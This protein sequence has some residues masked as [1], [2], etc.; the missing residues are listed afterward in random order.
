M[1]SLFRNLTRT[2]PRRKKTR[3]PVT[4][5]PTLEGLET[6]SLL[7]ANPLQNGLP[8]AS[9][10]FQQ[11]N[12]V[13]DQ[14]GVAQIL[15]PNL[16]NPWGIAL[17]SAG[18]PFWIANNGT[19]VA[20]LYGG[21][22]NGSSIAKNALV[23]SIPEGNPTGQVFNDTGDFVVTAPTGESGPAIFIFASET[24]QITGWNPRV[25]LPPP[26][27]QAQL[28]A[29]IDGAVFKGLAIAN[30]GSG[31]FLYAADFHDGQIDVFDGQFQQTTLA[32]SFTDPNLPQGFAPFNI[33]NLDGKLFVTYAQQDADGQN[34][35]PGD[36]AGFVDVFD[37]NGNFLQRVASGSP[38]NAPW[39]LALAPAGFGPFGGDLLVGN[40]GDGRINA[41]DPADNFAFRGQLLGTD[42][43]PVTIDGLWALKFGN[44]V[45]SGDPNT[46]FFTAGP[47]QETH[48][49]FG[50]LMVAT[51][52]SVDQFANND[53][54]L[55]LRVVTSGQSDSVTITDDSKAGTTTVVS[56]G[57][58][59]VFDHLFAHFDLELG[60]QMDQ[61]TFN[62][63]NDFSGRQADVNVSLGQGE[64][65]FT[66]NP[67]QTAITNQSDFNL[68]VVG[69]SGDDFVNVSFGNI[70]ESRVG[71]EASGL[72]GGQTPDTSGAA[73][74]SFTFGAR[75]AGIRNS[76]VDVNIVLGQGDTNLAF[77]YGADLGHL[78][79]TGPDQPG[80]FG[81]STFNVNITGSDQ[82]GD[83]DNVT[84]FANGE[85]NTGSTLN[86]NTQ[87]L[88]G[89][90]SFKGVFDAND[91]QIDDD[92]GAF[93]S[94]P[95][96]GGAAHFNI[97]GGS[98]DDAISFK[99]INQ[100][101]TIE[102]SGL[103]DIN[104]SGSVGRDNIKFD[105]GG[106]G[107][108]D[109]DPFELNATNR[110]FRLRVEGGQGDDTIKVNLANAATAT[111]AWDVAIVGGSGN[112]DITFIGT[113]PVGGT[114]TFGPDGFVFLDGGF[115]GQNTVD[116]FGN[117][118]VVVVNAQ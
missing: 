34:P 116:V 18:G 101:H 37:T 59:Q 5:R 71:V 4:F 58:T 63:A 86:F 21:D 28:G 69:Q 52:V 105:F 41:Y 25:P 51:T 31:N 93:I 10:L 57:R 45:S 46:L 30:N 54:T 14:V 65:H 92:G 90:N 15:D 32:G 78:A 12:L 94:G 108:T 99:S 109:D 98:G 16:V 56:D 7:S 83:V 11:T 102:L 39:G 82:E 23:V 95:H 64:N 84:L 88:A 113:N 60:S 42:G 70:L 96:L 38:L 62:L 3:K 97:H 89:N 91:F 80:D 110:A 49:L 61:L 77:N 75:R 48:G 87:F 115:G 66:F 20:T 19:G 114:P 13:S 74:D 103:F 8:P 55:G 85:V 50:S 106:A 33:Q 81:P 117:F 43:S 107:F 111:F 35:V 68:D 118:P 24:G 1:R 67:D 26:S 73:R 29:T 76:S 22:V 112:N 104:V 17:N 47:D 72:G 2:R 44:G 79:G 27:T 100:D 6:R 53:G 9:A 36:G 40:F